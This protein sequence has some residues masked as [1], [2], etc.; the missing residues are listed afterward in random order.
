MTTQTNAN[1]VKAF[2]SN[3]R[4]AEYG[5]IKALIAAA[6]CMQ[7]GNTDPMS[8]M[9]AV[10]N[11]KLAK[12]LKIVEKAKMTYATPIRN[13]LY[14]AGLVQG[15]KGKGQYVWDKSKDFGVTW[16]LDDYTF[17]QEIINTLK[18]LATSLMSSKEFKEAFPNPPT[19]TKN[20]SVEELQ[21]M[22]AKYLQKMQDDHGVKITGDVVITK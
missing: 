20:K 3:A 10:C 17:D 8:K 18:V 12:R 15:K 21:D 11:G 4:G 1:I 9:L 19:E 5:A 2:L 13:V 14:A 22:L 7:D 6:E 16:N